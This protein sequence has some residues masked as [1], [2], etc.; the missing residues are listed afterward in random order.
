MIPVAVDAPAW[1]NSYPDDVDPCDDVSVP[2]GPDF[3][4]EWATFVRMIASEWGA[5][6]YGLVAIEA[7]NE[8]NLRPFWGVRA[9]KPDGSQI[10]PPPTFAP[11]PQRFAS[12][13]NAANLAIEDWNGVPANAIA[14]GGLPAIEVLPGGMSP[15]GI[16]GSQE[17]A[18]IFLD[19]AL[20]G[21]NNQP[22]LVFGPGS[23][24]VDGLAVHLY[25][26]FAETEKRASRRVRDDYNA[27]VAVLNQNGYTDVPRWIT[28]LGFPTAPLGSRNVP[29]KAASPVRQC[30]RLTDAY[31][32]FANRSPRP[33]SFIIHRLFD[34]GPGGE[35]NRFGVARVDPVDQTPGDPEDPPQVLRKQA[36]REIRQLVKPGGSHQDLRCQA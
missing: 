34:P 4:D 1:A 22:H 10:T 32:R 9:T 8:P 13:V 15:E 7:W 12:I 25:A 18:D 19:N 5:E 11:Q 3:E 23:G 20:D 35:E 26:T 14:R 28:E 29:R 17:Q 2:P 24:T 31:M 36:Y 27:L 33:R 6:R 16:E 21:T 30:R